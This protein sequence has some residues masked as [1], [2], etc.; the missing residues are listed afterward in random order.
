MGAKCFT[1][2]ALPAQLCRESHDQRPQL[3]PRSVGLVDIKAETLTS[4]VTHQ[5]PVYPTHVCFKLVGGSVQITVYYTIA[6]C[7]ENNQSPF[8]EEINQ[9]N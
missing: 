1:P 5:D 7:E 8:F 3:L 4:E 9:T 6:E 2:D